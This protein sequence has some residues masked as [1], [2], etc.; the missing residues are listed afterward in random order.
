MP[1]TRR[2]KP[3][4]TRGPYRLVQ[5]PGRAA[6]EIVWYDEHRRR[7]RSRST[8]AEDGDAAR[9]ALDRLYLSEHRGGCPTCGRPFDSAGNPLVTDVIADHLASSADKPSFVSIRARCGHVVQFVLATDP[10]MRC[11]QVDERMVTRFR[12]WMDKRPIVSPSGAKR[13]RALSTTENSVL[14]WA[15]AINQAARE[16]RAARPAAFRPAP[17]KE[18]NRTP[19]YRADVPMLSAMFRFALASD[20]RANLLAFLRLSVATLARPDAVLGFSTAPAL[21]QFDAARGLMALNPTGRR[22]TKK[23][24]AVVP[25][26]EPMV[27]HLLAC[28]GLFVAGNPRTAWRSMATA[29]DLPGDGEAGLKL[30]RRSMAALLRRRGVSAEEV[31]MQLGHRAIDSTTELYAPFEPGFLAGAKTAIEGIMAEVETAAPGAFYRAVTA[32]GCEL[33]SIKRGGNRG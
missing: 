16:G 2:P 33:L 9:L 21:R 12:K 22:Q 1:S 15:A 10:A 11:Q 4:Y 31:E 5:R 32:S 7:E 18:V 20:R 26:P 6:Y 23:R 24:R 8:G 13:K 28:S 17:A 14:Q 30:I 25:A 29:L 19:A 3:L 27:P